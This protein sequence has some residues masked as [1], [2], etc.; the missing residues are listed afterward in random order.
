MCTLIVGP[1]MFR[2]C[3]EAESSAVAAWPLLLATQAEGPREPNARISSIAPR[4]GPS[5]WPLPDVGSEY[6]DAGSVLL[7]PRFGLGTR[8]R[9]G[10]GR[11]N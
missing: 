9:R 5:V 6:L 4:D 8:Q 11:C 2:I 1:G 10:G 7:K 3:C